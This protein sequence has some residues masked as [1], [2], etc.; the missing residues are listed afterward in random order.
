MGK[1]N[2][3]SGMISN[4]LCDFS[5]KI[6][7]DNSALVRENAFLREEVNRLSVLL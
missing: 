3:P 1:A 6:V 4:F 2:T 5:S 7:E